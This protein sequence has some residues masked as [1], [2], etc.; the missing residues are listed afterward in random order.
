MLMRR[1]WNSFSFFLVNKESG[2]VIRSDL[3]V[4]K[5]EQLIHQKEWVVSWF[6]LRKRKKCRRRP[7]ITSIEAIKKGISIKEVT[8]TITLDLD[9]MEEQS[10]KF[11]FLLTNLLR[12]HTWLQK[13]L[14]DFIVV[15]LGVGV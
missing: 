12:I 5:R 7:K 14:E 15:W 10:W 9:R 13:Y 6:K 2:I 4:F 1:K 3:I 11:I 8:K